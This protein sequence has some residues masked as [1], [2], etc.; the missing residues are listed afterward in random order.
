M[1]CGNLRSIAAFACIWTYVP[2][3]IPWDSIP[4]MSRNVFGK[5]EKKRGIASQEI[6]EKKGHK[7]SLKEFLAPKFSAKKEKE[8]KII[9]QSSNLLS[10][11]FGGFKKRTVFFDCQKDRE[12]DR[13][14]ASKS[15]S[16]LG[17][18]STVSYLK[19]SRWK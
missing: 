10:S 17:F 12:V 6:Y 1:G 19:K 8:S 5:R 13:R 18:F 14:E 16:G 7:G 11:F 2:W 3:S 9:F 15:C 4:W